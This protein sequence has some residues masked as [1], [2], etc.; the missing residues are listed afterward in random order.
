MGASMHREEDGTT[1]GRTKTGR[2]ELN[3]NNIQIKVTHCLPN[4]E[5]RLLQTG[6]LYC[7]GQV[8]ASSF[9]KPL[10]FLESLHI[11]SITQSCNGLEGETFQLWPL[12]RSLVLHHSKGK[13]TRLYS[14]KT[15]SLKITMYSKNFEYTPQNLPTPL[16]T[17]DF[18][19]HH[20]CQGT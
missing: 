12:Q 18:P 15:S 17:L 20:C 11:C 3:F 10:Q 8:P 16:A 2:D 7:W 1:H 9:N 4:S 19:A 14:F 5:S 6:L 13:S